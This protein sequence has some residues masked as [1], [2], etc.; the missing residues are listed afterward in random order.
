MGQEHLTWRKSTGLAIAVSGVAL[1]QAN[2]SKAAGASLLG[3]LFILASAATFALFT[4][5]GK[6]HRGRFDGLTVNTF[7][8]AGSALLLLPVTIYSASRFSFA[9]VTWAGWASLL[10]MALLPSLFCYMIYFHALRYVPASRIST[11]AY[12]QPL[13]ATVFAISLLNE[14]LSGSL[15][16]GGLLVLFGVFL[17]ERS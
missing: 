7:A 11:L 2:P 17:T 10:Y 14:S 8:Y 1:L 9:R 16:S 15:I 12:L 4:V 13:L 3:D 6:R 5:V